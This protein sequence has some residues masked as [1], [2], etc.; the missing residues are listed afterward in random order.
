MDPKDG[1]L[2]PLEEQRAEYKKRRMIAMPISGL[3]AWA[4][5]GIG[6]LYLT[7]GK[8]A[9][10]LFV[11]TG[12]IAY[13]GMLISKFTGEDFLDKT[14]PKNTFDG[15]FYQS[16]GSAIMVFAIAIPFFFVDK[17]SAPMSVGILTSLM[18]VQLGWIIQHWIGLVPLAIVVLYAI[19]IW[20]LERRW[21]EANRAS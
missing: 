4:I 3:I 16:M 10:L 1:L 13:L 9:L 19:A 12:S 5:V 8:A 18:W 21:R 17:T 6:G 11:A 14:R 7:T 2:R 20:V 15:L